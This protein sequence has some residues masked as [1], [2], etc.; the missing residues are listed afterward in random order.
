[1]YRVSSGGEVLAVIASHERATGGDELEGDVDDEDVDWRRDRCEERSAPHELSTS[2]E[3]KRNGHAAT[4]DAA[5]EVETTTTVKLEGR[6]GGRGDEERRPVTPTG[7]GHWPTIV[8]E[9]VRRS[10]G[11]SGPRPP[12][13]EFRRDRTECVTVDEPREP[14]DQP[15]GGGK[16]CTGGGEP[17]EEPAEAP[18]PTLCHSHPTCHSEWITIHEC[19]A[20]LLS[21]FRHGRELEGS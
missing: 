17:V 21:G 6:Q 9:T 3:G 1:M 2:L 12:V 10:R 4:D 11:Y 7:N 18:H 19:K 8:H 14:P 5:G 16:V 15:G 13:D 20:Y